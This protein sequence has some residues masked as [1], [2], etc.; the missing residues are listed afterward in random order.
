MCDP[1]VDSLPG[2]GLPRNI[3]YTVP[4]A[5][6]KRPVAGIPI[7]WNARAPTDHAGHQVGTSSSGLAVSLELKADDAVSKR[8]CASC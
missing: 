2:D 1:V 6:S 7:T 8:L 5:P 4:I 3:E